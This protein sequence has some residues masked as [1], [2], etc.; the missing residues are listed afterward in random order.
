LTV[1]KAADRL[2]RMV[3]ACSMPVG[4]L[5]WTLGTVAEDADIGLTFDN[6]AL[7]NGRLTEHKGL[8]LFGT[9]LTHPVNRFSTR[10]TRTCG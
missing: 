3:M 1:R 7:T 5:V 6:E 10:D 2:K 8:G 9:G 4:E